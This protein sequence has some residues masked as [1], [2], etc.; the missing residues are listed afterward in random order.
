LVCVAPPVALDIGCLF[1]RDVPP[2]PAAFR[3]HD[4]ALK[5]SFV[6]LAPIARMFD[7]EIGKM[8]Q[9]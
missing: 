6:H 4:T 7:D 8:H 2:F 5:E 3:R 1:F 9:E